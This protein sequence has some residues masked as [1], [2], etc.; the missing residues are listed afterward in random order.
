MEKF[1]DESCIIRLRG[2]GVK[3]TRVYD[4]QKN[5]YFALDPSAGLW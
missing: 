3:L 1:A 2:R 5:L 4:A